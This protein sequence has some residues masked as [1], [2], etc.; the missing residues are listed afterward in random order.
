MSVGWSASG[1]L[2]ARYYVSAGALRTVIGSIVATAL[3]L[4]IGSALAL[5]GARHTGTRLAVL[6]TSMGLALFAALGAR[7][8][9]RNSRQM[10]EVVATERQ[11]GD[12]IVGYRHLYQGLG[13]Y[14][15]SRMIQ[16]Q[17][18]GEIEHG[19]ELAPDRDQ[20]FWDDPARLA[21]LWTSG[22]GVFIATDRR[23]VA[24]LSLLLDPPPR[25]V[26]LDL[27]LVVLTNR[28]RPDGNGP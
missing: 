7:G 2:G 1:D 26:P 27:G 19:M 25:V 21:E 28:P 16:V 20:Y 8:V 9:G 5:R 11:P 14:T 15:A 22:R 13:F 12:A 3:A 17:A 18:P 10:A 6:V 24:E 4:V 23:R